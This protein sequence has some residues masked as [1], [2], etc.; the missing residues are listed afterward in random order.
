MH[1]FHGID[2]RMNSISMNI[3]SRRYQQVDIL[4]RMWYV[5][6]IPNIHRLIRLSDMF[7]GPITAISLS[8][9]GP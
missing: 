3:L 5:G 2:T 6:N 4:M 1:G 7:R 8:V 9:Q